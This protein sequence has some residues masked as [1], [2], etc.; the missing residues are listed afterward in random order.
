LGSQ[1]RP[2]LL[3]RRLD[4]RSDAHPGRRHQ[5]RPSRKR[6]PGSRRRPWRDAL[7]SVGRF[8]DI[9]AVEKHLEGKELTH[10]NVK[11]L[12]LPFPLFSVSA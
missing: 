2:P 6:I 11:R 3:R 7:T 9:F 1:R 4:H 10:C 5:A 8:R 12:Y